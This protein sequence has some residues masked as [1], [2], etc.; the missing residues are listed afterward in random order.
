ME[1]QP[2]FYHT[3][4]YLKRLWTSELPSLKYTVGLAMKENIGNT[5]ASNAQ[6]MSSNQINGTSEESKA[7]SNSIVNSKMQSTIKNSIE[8]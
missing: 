5:S 8:R 3:K 4:K 2:T 1:L 7:Q 6:Q